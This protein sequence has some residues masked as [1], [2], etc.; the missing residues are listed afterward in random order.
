MATHMPM[1]QRSSASHA[2]SHPP[3]CASLLFVLLAGTTVSANV[4]T[5]HMDLQTEPTAPTTDVQIARGN[6]CASKIQSVGYV[7]QYRYVVDPWGNWVLQYH[8]VYVPY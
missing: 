5:N 7:Y 2:A 8:W 1:R 3:Q 6:Y 4:G